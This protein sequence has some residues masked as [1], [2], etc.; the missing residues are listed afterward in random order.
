MQRESHPRM[1]LA[2]FVALV[3][4]PVACKSVLGLDAPQLDPC[5]DVPCADS[6][7]DADAADDA[8]ASFDATPESGAAVG[9]R[10]GGGTFAETRCSGNTPICC[11]VGDG[12]VT[13][14]ACRASAA[15]CE[16]YAIA[17]AS[18]DDC[19]GNDVCCHSAS[20]IRCVPQSAC[21]NDALVCA[22]DGAAD[23]C[24]TGSRCNVTFTIGGDGSPYYGCGT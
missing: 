3:A 18:N 16:G 14:Y 5:A 11:A 22:P 7:S 13:A 2:L 12:G 8:R 20:Q 19:S 24:P 15:A 4:T 6:G 10:C 21:A 1:R 9:L 23:Q 17:C